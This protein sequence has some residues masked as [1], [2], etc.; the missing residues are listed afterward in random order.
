MLTEGTVAFSNPTSTERY[1]GQDTG[2]YSLVVTLDDH[3]ALR[4]QGVKVKEY[5]GKYQR[6]F[7]SKFEIDVLD[8]EGNPVKGEIPR[9]SRVRL[10]YGLGK[11]PHPVH[12]VSPYLNKVRV[13]EFAERTEDG[14]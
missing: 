5:E 3:S 6:K 1:N 4:A 9:G 13:L 10:Q 8:S 2:K 14:F 12:G 11:N 7:T